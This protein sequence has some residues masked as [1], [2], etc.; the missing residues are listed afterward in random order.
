[1]YEF[2]VKG[3]MIAC[4]VRWLV[5]KSVDKKNNFGKWINQGRV[6]NTLFFFF[7]NNSTSRDHYLNGTSGH[8]KIT[9]YL[10]HRFRCQCLNLYIIRMAKCAGTI[11]F[12]YL[13]IIRIAYRSFRINIEK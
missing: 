8:Q 12:S 3:I 13:S 10:I 6:T 4:I 9:D 11:S 1:M 5:R 2:D 7:L